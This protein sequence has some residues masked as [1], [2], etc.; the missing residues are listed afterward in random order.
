MLL[1][2]IFIF[3]SSF[4]LSKN[5]N[6]RQNQNDVKHKLTFG[7]D[8]KKIEMKYANIKEQKC[9][10]DLRY[11]LDLRA[12]KIERKKEIKQKI[13]KNGEKLKKTYN[14]NNN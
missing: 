4:S 11:K 7:H 12:N 13:F 8:R 1:Y 6:N 5:N 10:G 2:F 3:V 9:F 14:N